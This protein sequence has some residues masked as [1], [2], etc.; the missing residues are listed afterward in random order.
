V[1]RSS[2]H[3]VPLIR[4]FQASIDTV[5]NTTD[6]LRSMDAKYTVNNE[7]TQLHPAPTSNREVS[8]NII[9]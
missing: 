8:P 6:E 5:K 7:A 1:P 3:D 4:P 9:I 2:A